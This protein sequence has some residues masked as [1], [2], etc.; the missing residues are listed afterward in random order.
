MDRKKAV[1]LLS[2][3]LDSTTLLA[4]VSSQGYDVHA[5]SFRYGQRHA[6]ELSAAQKIAERYA[7]V[8]HVVLD[9]DLRAFGGSALTADM[10]VPKDRSVGDTGEIPITYV[11]ARN[12]IFLSFALAF[13]EV[14]GAADIFI[15]VNALDYSGYP[16]CRP[17][18]IH[19][20]ERMA[21]LAT[22]AGL[23]N[24]EEESRI[25][26]NTPLIQLTKREIIELGLGL[27]VDY[28]LTTSCYD[29]R[30]SG[31]ACGHCDACQLRLRGFDEAGASDP[32]PYAAEARSTR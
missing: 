24:A 6:T 19:A 1:L 5:L 27:G 4:L 21:R 16:D 30:D 14:L 25:R 22:R 31:E 20:F 9:V 7:V 29:P 2:G 18:F 12:T 13:A 28:S 10:E 23:E 3:G 17:E 15:G 11:P 8:Q 26:I 32:I